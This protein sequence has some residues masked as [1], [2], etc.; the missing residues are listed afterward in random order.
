MGAGGE[1][2]DE[3]FKRQTSSC[4]INEYQRYNIQHV[5][6]IINNTAVVMCEVFLGESTCSGVLL[7]R[8]KLFFLSLI[9][10]LC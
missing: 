1:E 9:L 7:T 6:V 8:E 3:G 2:L 4:K 5:N 10:Y